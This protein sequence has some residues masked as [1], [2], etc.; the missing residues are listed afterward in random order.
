MSRKKATGDILIGQSLSQADNIFLV[1]IKR[2][3]PS[4]NEPADFVA[5]TDD[6]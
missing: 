2:R 6:G 5:W 1:Q 4:E 3:Q